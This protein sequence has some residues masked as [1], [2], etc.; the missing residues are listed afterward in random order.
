M[1]MFD[2]AP[3]KDILKELRR[4]FQY[5]F[6]SP[7]LHRGFRILRLFSKKQKPPT[8]AAVLV[9]IAMTLYELIAPA[10]CG[11][12]VA[13]AAVAAAASFSIRWWM[14]NKASS[15]RSETPILSYTLRR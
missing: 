10:G 15:S 13:A 1:E 9:S 8:W 3:R 12:G 7:G 2:N 6:L 5:Y 14:V 4:R 11:G